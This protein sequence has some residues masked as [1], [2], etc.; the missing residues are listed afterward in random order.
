MVRL[1]DTRYVFH[2]TGVLTLL[3]DRISLQTSN[4]DQTIVLICRV[5]CRLLE[6]ADDLSKLMAKIMQEKRLIRNLLALCPRETPEALDI[7]GLKTLYLVLCADILHYAPVFVDA[8]GLE[9]ILMILKRKTADI[10]A[11]KYGFEIINLVV[12]HYPRYRYAHEFLAHDALI[13]VGYWCLTAKKGIE[14]DSMIVYRRTKDLYAQ[15]TALESTPSH[16]CKNKTQRKSPK[17][18]QT[19]K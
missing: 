18:L 9:R 12:C 5:F 10:K 17:K 6:P 16:P 11:I 2:E 4:E 3:L 14:N 19:L 15:L 13:L 8:N 7:V 1:P